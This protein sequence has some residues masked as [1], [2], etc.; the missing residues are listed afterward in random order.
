M[1]IL[2]INTFN[3]SF[4]LCLGCQAGG[5]GSPFFNFSLECCN[6]QGFV[7]LFCNLYLECVA[8]RVSGNGGKTSFVDFIISLNISL[9][10]LRGGGPVTITL[11][12]SI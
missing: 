4:K 11:G 12:G 9:G 3:F 5:T 10:C 2:L 6:H 7:G 1:F 8:G